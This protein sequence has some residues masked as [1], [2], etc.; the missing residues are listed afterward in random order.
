MSFKFY[1]VGGIVRDRLLGIESDDYDYTVVSDD[2]TKEPNIVFQELEQYLTKQGYKIFLST[3]EMFTVR[4]M[5]PNGHKNHGIVAD[6]VLARREIGY[7]EGTR[8]P[9]LVLGTLEDDLIRRDFTVNAMA[10]DEETGEIIDLFGGKEDLKEGILRTPRKADKTLLDD[11]LRLLRALRFSVTKNFSIDGEIFFAIRHN[12]EILTK[13]NKVV[14]QE[15]IQTELNKMFKHNTIKAMRILV[16][17]DDDLG[18]SLLPI[19]FKNDYKLQ[20]TNKK[21]K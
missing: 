4:A 7:I 5:F 6:F 11:P 10:L 8:N 1:L 13:L 18:G 19:L 12:P 16:D 9:I 14:S 2:I 15:R 21:L 20:M 17:W 3:P